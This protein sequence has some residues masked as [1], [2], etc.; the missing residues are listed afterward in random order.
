MYNKTSESFF[1]K[2]PNFEKLIENIVYPL[3]VDVSVTLDGN[4]FIDCESK[5]LV[6]SSKMN[7]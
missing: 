5:F 4:I 3:E 2:T 1:G 7:L 6:Y